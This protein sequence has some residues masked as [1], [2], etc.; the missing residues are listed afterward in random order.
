MQTPRRITLAGESILNRMSM[1]LQSKL[2]D[3]VSIKAELL[4][5]AP[6]SYIGFVKLQEPRSPRAQ[7]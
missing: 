2:G 4:E 6:K 3:F 7:P 1:M 5:G